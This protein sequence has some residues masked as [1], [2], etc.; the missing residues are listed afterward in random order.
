MKTQDRIE[1]FFRCYEQYST[2]SSILIPEG[3]KVVAHPEA[4]WQ[5]AILQRRPS[6]D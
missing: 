6:I 5:T 3:D 2:A 1:I 4:M